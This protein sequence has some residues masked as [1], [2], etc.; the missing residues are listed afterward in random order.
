[1]ALGHAAINDI[2]QLIQLKKTPVATTIPTPNTTTKKRQSS[3]NYNSN[4]CT[5]EATTT[6]KN[7]NGVATIP[8]YR[9]NYGQHNFT[10]T[11]NNTLRIVSSWLLW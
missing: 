9:G 2:D 6:N 10:T 1:M 4:H 11:N 8:L 7:K 3:H 5:D